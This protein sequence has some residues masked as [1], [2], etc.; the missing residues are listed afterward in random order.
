MKEYTIIRRPENLCWSEIPALS[1]DTPM[2]PTNVR[3][4]AK[5]QLCYDDEFLH[6]RLSAVES[7][8][9]AEHKGLL[10][11]ICEDSCLEFF[12]SP[13]FGDLR[14]FNL[15]CNLNGA[16][17]LGMGTGIDDLIRLVFAEGSPFV[18]ETK[19]TEDGWEVYHAIPHKFI[20]LFFPEY[21]PASGYKMRANFYKC[22]DLTDHPHYLM[23]NPVP[24]A[25]RASFHQP[26][27][28]GVLRFS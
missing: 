6:V 25:P 28:F 3:V 10:C 12:F 2:H 11:E 14:Y 20:Q 15:E 22:G 1:I 19:Q 7:N 4:E 13:V 8:I 9:R 21:A 17:Y 26:D 27:Y 16:I 5:A 23:W 18:P 24:Q